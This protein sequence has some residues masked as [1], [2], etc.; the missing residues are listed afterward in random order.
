MKFCKKWP[1]FDSCRLLSLSFSGEKI[2][3]M[4]VITQFKA[5]RA[6]ISEDSLKFDYSSNSWSKVVERNFKEYD[7]EIHKSFIKAL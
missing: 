4:I 5:L 7:R 1:D 6:L 2:S 3:K